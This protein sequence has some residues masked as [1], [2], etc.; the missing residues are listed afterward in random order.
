[1]DFNFLKQNNMKHL[2]PTEDG[3]KSSFVIVYSEEDIRRICKDH[4]NK[5]FGF[6]V[7]ERDFTMDMYSDYNDGKITTE[8]NFDI[9]EDA[10]SDEEIERMPE[11][12]YSRDE[13]LETVLKE[14]FGSP[15]FLN[16]YVYTEYP[17]KIKVEVHMPLEHFVDLK[18]K[19]EDEI[20]TCKSFGNWGV[21]S[22]C[23][24]CAY[25]Q[26][27]DSVTDETFEKIEKLREEKSFITEYD[28]KNIIGLEVDKSK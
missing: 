10:L 3:R 13:F 16:V 20:I 19:A 11:V 28:I 17:D 7:K 22:L 26:I 1:M 18:N 9:D 2:I 8:F 12:G 4:L 14:E 23:G 6:N 5:K 24:L 27:C 25:S 15:R 21:N